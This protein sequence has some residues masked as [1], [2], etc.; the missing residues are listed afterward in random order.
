MDYVLGI[1]IGG[2]SI[3]AGIFSPDGELLSQRKIPTPALVSQDAFETVINGLNKL[4]ESQEATADDII[5]VGVDI[6]GPVAD[7]G[8][9]GFLANIQLD[10][11]GLIHAISMTFTKAR[12]AFVNDANAA[13]LGEMWAGSA[14]GQKN[15]VLVALGTGVGAGVVCG[16]R[17]VAGSFGAGG[18]MGHITVKQDE[19]LACGC[20][21]HGCLEQYASATGLVRMYLED[22]ARQGVT[23]APVEHPTDT[24]TVFNAL[25]EGDHSA[26]I[27]V[28]KMCEYLAFAMAQ[29]SCVTDPGLFLIGG[30]VAGAF[31]S[32]APVLRQCYYETA[33]PTCKNVRIEAAAL[34]NQAA[35]YGCAYEAL[36]QRKE[37][38]GE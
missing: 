16:G 37:H 4:L 23:P 36:R 2:T 11:E 18:E 19:V 33:I 8:T 25:A 1:D 29:I 32:F 22:C 21:R 13:A 5:A 10:P 26:Q 3:K 38:L 30:G 20:G 34:G 15:F 35:M 31:A 12:T 7:D 17:L 27:A 24:I 9:V 6:P 14:R 28:N